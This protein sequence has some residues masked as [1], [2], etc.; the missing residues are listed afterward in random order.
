MSL[1]KFA[2]E[3][4]FYPGGQR[5]DDRYLALNKLLRQNASS[6]ELLFDK[7]PHAFGYADKFNAGLAENIK[8][9]KDCYDRLIDKLKQHLVN[10]TKNT[11]MLAENKGL[12]GKMSLASSIREW[13]ESLDP[14]CFGHLF[15]DGT[16]KCLS[17]FESITND[18]SSFIIRLAKT[19]TG[20]RIE[21]WDNNTIEIFGKKLSQYKAT[22]ES[23]HAE[24]KT[25][26]S[27]QA[28]NYQVTFVDTDG[29]STTKS[30]ER[31][32]ST[33]RGKLLYN[34]ITQSLESMGHAISEQ[35]KRQ[36]LMD[37][38]KNLC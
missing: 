11:F 9:A 8:A 3:S 6:Y 21:D 13:C 36:I 29:T 35:E 26:G 38:L 19:A 17:L 14:A 10:K 22:A 33:K 15:A 1:P 30:F 37:I 7:L 20:L 4:R 24:T 2:K 18:E 34:Q 12:E 23:Y 5:I 27:L 16:D 28:S 31:V 32:E 25:Q